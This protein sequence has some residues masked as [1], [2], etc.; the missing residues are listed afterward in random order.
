M[1]EDVL[2]YRDIFVKNKTVYQWAA[3]LGQ[4]HANTIRRRTL[5][6]GD[7]WRLDKCVISIKGE[8]F[9]LLQVVEQKINNSIAFT[10][11]FLHSLLRELVQ[12]DVP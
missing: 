11:V 8:H 1:V 2:A 12:S 6:L 10:T 7:T 4:T 9:I 3:I 5:R